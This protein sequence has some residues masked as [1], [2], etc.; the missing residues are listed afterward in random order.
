MIHFT[1]ALVQS[2]DDFITEA[3]DVRDIPPSTI[4]ASRVFNVFIKYTLSRETK[5]L[6]YVF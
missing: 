3:A 5:I 2:P 4:V 1:P 6:F